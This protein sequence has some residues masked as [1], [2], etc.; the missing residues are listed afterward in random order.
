MR[1]AGCITEQELELRNKMRSLWEQHIAWTRMSII[2]IVEGLGD[3]DYVI[4]RLLRNPKDFAVVFEIFYGKEKAK[5][6]EELF[7]Q[8]LVIA[9]QL[10]NA[11]KA[12]DNEGVKD[13]EERWYTNADDIAKFL[14]SLNPYWSEEDFRHML[15]EHLA[16]TEC[17]AIA[18]LTK[19][20]EKR[21]LLFDKIEDQALTMADAFSDGIVKQFPAKFM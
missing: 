13:A 16:L 4:A 8:H 6:F 20:Y 18:L 9:A 11:A 15:H 14:H 7:T 5:E 19:D 12:Q 21:I 2:S 10:V 17:E 3:V 1:N